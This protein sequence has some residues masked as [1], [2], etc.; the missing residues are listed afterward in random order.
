[1]TSTTHNPKV[2]LRRIMSLKEQSSFI[3]CID[4]I[5]QSGE[6]LRNEFVHHLADDITVIFLSFE[7][8]NKPEYANTFLEA[9]N[10]S[11]KEIISNLQLYLPQPQEQLPKRHLLIIDSLNY[12]ACENVGQFLSGIASPA[13]TILATF[14]Q[15]TPEWRPMDLQNYPTSLQLLSY[16][17]N[18]VLEISPNVSID[19]EILENRLNRFAIPKGLNGKSYYVELTNKRKSGRSISYKFLFDSQAH[20]YDVIIDTSGNSTSEEPEVLEGLTTFNLGLSDKQRLA[21]ENVDLPFLEAQSFNTGGAI[22]YEFEKDDDYDE[23]DPYEDP[24]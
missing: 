9:G 23:E 2:L 3:L 17:A 6:L 4:S 14:H 22:V 19:E 11:F 16:V 1:M 20:D 7:T 13:T 18:T 15:S 24:F 12:I 5:A 10:K 21:R 8:P